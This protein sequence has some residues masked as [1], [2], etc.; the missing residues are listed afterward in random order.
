MDKNGGEERKEK[1]QLEERF[2]QFSIKKKMHHLCPTSL[3]LTCSV[4]CLAY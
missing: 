1:R 3:E 2:L 4:A